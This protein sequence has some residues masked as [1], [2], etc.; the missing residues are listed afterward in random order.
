MI[1]KIV[2][3]NVCSPDEGKTTELYRPQYP[4]IQPVDDAQDL[5]YTGKLGCMNRLCT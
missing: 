1:P 5:S 3:M 2:Q 4:D